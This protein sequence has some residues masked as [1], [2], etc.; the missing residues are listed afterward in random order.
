MPTKGQPACCMHCG[1]PLGE[2]HRAVKRFVP[3]GARFMNG[4]ACEGC[5]DGRL[6][7][8]LLYQ[9]DVCKAPAGQE[10]RCGW[11]EEWRALKRVSSDE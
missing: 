6:R 7:G 8:S 9:A 1:D 5:W 4:R 2:R 10:C 3:G 11:C